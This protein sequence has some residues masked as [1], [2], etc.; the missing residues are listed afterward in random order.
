[1]QRLLQPSYW[2]SGIHNAALMAVDSVSPTLYGRRYRA[3]RQYTMLSSAR[4]RSLYDGL[5]RLAAEGIRGDV[6]ECGTARGGSAALMGLAMLDDPIS[7]RLWLFDTFEGMPKPT[8]D[9]PDYELALRYEG[10]CRGGLEEVSALLGSLGLSDRTS[11][12]KGLFQDTVANAQVDGIAMLHLDGDWY[13]SVM[14]C[15][16][17]FYDKVVPGGIVQIDDFG[18]WAGARTAVREFF[19]KR[20][21]DPDLRHVDYTG[22]VFIKP[23]A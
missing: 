18:Y 20:K 6:V 9:D 17:A 19:A 12:V 14:V 15:L 4:L 8:L 7:R 2:S 3:I 22:R 1:M 10:S 5:K 21:I 23:G 16:E 11:L 13:E